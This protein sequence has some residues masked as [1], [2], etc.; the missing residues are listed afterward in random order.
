MKWKKEI[1]NKLRYSWIY[2]T[3]N[4]GKER[5]KHLHLILAE[6]FFRLLPIENKVVITSHHGKQY[7]AEPKAISDYLCNNGFSDKIVWILPESVILPSN[8]KRVRSNS[9]KMM[10]ELMTAKVWVDNGRKDFWIKKRKNQTYIQTWHG[11]V[12][13]KYVEK[14]A[15]HTLT[16][17]YIKNAIVDSKNADYIVAEDAWR[18]RN[19]QESF[20]YDGN[21]LECFFYRVKPENYSDIS[22][23]V[24]K[25]YSVNDDTKLLFYAPTFR[26]DNS[27]DYYIS[28]YTAL[29]QALTE[30]TN[31][32]WKVIVRMHPNVSYK[33]NCL[34][35]DENILNGTEYPNFDDL[36]IACD[37]YI[38]DYSGGMFDA[39]RLYK[40]TFLYAPDFEHYKANERGI[41]FK[42]EQLPAVLAQNMKELMD[43]IKNFNL[44]VYR[45]K[46]KKLND[47]LGYYEKD[48]ASTCGNIVIEKLSGH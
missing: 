44:D 19:I 5:V 45:E 38:T 8:I 2:I 39:I 27:F 21:I 43:N 15:E 46:A 11:P 34:K 23:A 4:T 42:I 37:A 1:R 36:L 32:K 16:A 13:I 9:L 18:K 33:S 20:W 7:N 24:R 29:I 6:S 14:D 17:A 30:K 48:A 40:P 35:Y 3:Y 41:Y 22:R 12:C 47:E 28:D 25:F 26:E 10:Y 31:V